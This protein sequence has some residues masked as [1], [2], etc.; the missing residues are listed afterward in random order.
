MQKRRLG[1]TE[2]NVSV[3]GFGGIKLPG[4]PKDDAVK[5]INRALDLGINFI[6]TARNYGDSEEKIGYVLK[7]RRNECYIATK[8][9]NLESSGLM[10]ELE[11]SLRNL[12]TDVIDLYQLH[13]VSDSDA[14]KKVMSSGGALEGAKKAQSQGKIRHIGISIHRD[15]DT[16]RSAIRS[17]EFETIMLAYSPLDQEG[18]ADEILPMAKEH[19]M[20]VIIMKSLSGGLLCLPEYERDKSGKDPIA[21]GSIRFVISNEN[22]TVAIPGITCMREIEENA[23]LGNMPSLS[24]K[25]KSDLLKSIGALK[26][27]FR[28][29]QICLRCGYCQPCTQEI[30]IPTVFRAVDIYR[31]YPDQLKHIG[32]ELYSSLEVKADACVECKKCIEK[33]PAGLDIPEKLKEAVEIFN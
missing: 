30:I 33:C 19:D 10:Q 8:T 26:K 32:T 29:G 2:L 3:I 16:M 22:V 21:S 9:A 7:D 15:I 6:D 28:Y 1:R 20:G 12:Q 27:E 24:E 31:S 23:G 14:Y 13:S 4:V 25:E 18:V 17:G 5:I 11:T